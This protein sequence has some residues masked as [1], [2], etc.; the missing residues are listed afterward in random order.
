MNTTHAQTRLISVIFFV[1]L[2]GVLLNSSPARANDIF[3]SLT[4]NDGLAHTDANC[5]V[6]DSTGLIWIGTNSGLQSFDGYQFQTIDYYPATQRIFKSH[7]RINVMECSK[8]KLWIGTD[9]GLTCLDLNTHLYTPYTVVAND[10]SIL[11]ERI[12]QLSVDNVNHRLWIHTDSKLCIV[13]I[14][15]S[16]NTLYILDWQNDYDRE[17]SW[18]QIKPIIHRSYT[19]TLTDHYLV[20]LEVDN[21]KIKIRKSYDIHDLVSPDTHINAISASDKFL[22]LRSSQ[23][24]I[25]ISFTATNELDTENIAFINFHKTNPNIPVNTHG[26]FITKDDETLWCSYFGGLFEVNKPFTPNAN[27]NIYLGNEKNTNSSL[28]RINSLFIDTYNNLWVPASNKGLFYRSLCLSPFHCIPNKLLS[29]I[30]YSKS[31]IS[32]IAVQENTA[33]WMIVEGG[34]LVRYDMKSQTTE[35]IKLTV[36]QGAADGLQRLSI[37]SDQKKLFIG[38]MQGLIVYEIQTGKSYW[39][40]GKNSKALKNTHISIT[41]TAEDRWGR[42]WISSWR[43]GVYCIKN[44]FSD[45]SIEYVLTPRTKLSIASG[46]ISDMYMED[47]AILLCTTQGMN[48]IWLNDQGEIENISAYHTDINSEHSIS[49]DFIACIAQQNDSTYWLG[50]I[51]GGLNKITIHS[52]K[53]NDYSAI[54]YTKNNGLTSND[55][56]IL[57]L[58]HE[59]NVWI[60]GNGIT[61]LN[62]QTNE[63]SIYELAD[64]LQSNSFKIGAGYQSKEGTIFMGSV[65]GLNYFHPRDFTNTAYYHPKLIFSNLYING[66]MVIPLSNYDGRVTLAAIL[67]NTKHFELSHNQDNF[68]ISF[69]ALGYNLSNRIMYRYRMSGYD[70][71]W[72][73]VPYST[74]RAYYSNL[75]YGDYKFELQVSTDRGFNWTTPGKA[76]TISVIPPWWLSGWAKTLYVIAIILVISVIAYQHNKEQRLKREKHFQELQRIS[77]EEKHQSKMRFFMNIS[78]ELKTPLTLIMLAAERM[79]QFNLSKECIPILSN[80]KKMLSL[81]TELVDI[82]KADL[83][84]DQLA[85]SHQS[86][87]ELVRQLY[88]EMEPWAEKKDIRIEYQSED[89]LEMD[90]DRDKVGKLI[91]NLISNAIKY[92]PKGGY[93]KLNLKKGNANDI[94]PLYAVAHQEGSIPTKTPLCI[95]TVQDSGVGISEESIKYIYERF[96]QVKDN[97]LNHLGSGIGLAIAKNMV[98]LHKGSIIVSSKR[99][100]GTEFIIALPISGKAATAEAASPLFDI[101]DFIDNQYIEFIPSEAGDEE[102]VP[103]ANQDMEPS[104]PTLLIVEDNKE[105]QKA[106]KEHFSSQYNIRV[107]SDGLTGLK[108]CETLYPDLII[109]DVMMPGI[110]GIEMCKRIRE[111]LSI[112]YIPII[113]LTAKGNTDDQIEGYESGADIYIPKPFSIRLLEINIKRLLAQK[114]RWLKQEA[115]SLPASVPASDSLPKKEKLTFEQQLKRI[116]ESQID[117]PDFSINYICNELCLGRTKLYYEM[118]KI[119]D[120]PLADYIRNIRLEKATYL[121][122]HTHLNVNE[123]M[124]EVG[125]INNSHFSKTFKLKYG[126]TPS[127]YKRTNSTYL[128]T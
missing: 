94:H 113:L 43:Y 3:K 66:E 37:S 29:D 21:N 2:N 124:S 62:P 16:T 10:Q 68:I 99:T 85:L 4:I 116:I 78:H 81:I 115:P 83:G 61:R 51:G 107:A 39:L 8:N 74:A 6:Q 69:S 92:T 95:L 9:S 98:L 57:F 14:E 91:I 27:I 96:F 49:S 118:K 34:S 23:E 30:G 80:A 45:P 123:I 65:E 60:G 108:M 56:E 109:S 22:Y 126:V 122:V 84:L 101:K 24:C 106:L 20:Q 127:E 70:K 110:D 125:F 71:D 26:F 102:N 48:K 87:S 28:V 82:R 33:I 12:K 5:V 120:L 19:W 53:D 50:T 104:L 93:I 32:S 58:D 77:D 55:C 47:N 52:R 31:E 114:E 103:T 90:F 41:K 79:A 59:Q 11:K 89:E 1:V 86:M 7:N 35:R 128:R 97:N 13:R 112:A 111:N 15:E 88:T 75:P 117:N 42:L 44:P 121:L 54:T 36:T 119:S 73:I 76:L 64:G 100:I 18:H 105:L 67:N 25:R 38:L 72:Q 63:I 40:I 46:F 17:I